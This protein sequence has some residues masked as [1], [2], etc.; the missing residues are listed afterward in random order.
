MQYNQDLSNYYKDIKEYRRL[1]DKLGQVEAHITKTIQQ[2][3]LYHIKDKPTVYEQIKTLQELY[4]PT[5]A[6]QEYRVQKAYEA[7]KVLHARRS[8]IED[9]CSEFI[10]AYN[11][12]KQLDLPE[13][14]GFRAHK[15]L[16][17]A[18]KQVDAAYAASVSLDIFKAEETWNLNRNVPIPN[19]SQLSTIL[20]NFLRYHRTT[21]SRKTNIH[22]GVFGATLNGQESPYKKKRSRGDETP[23]KPCL[24]GDNHFWGQC[25]YIDTA[26][27]TRGFVE[28]PEK[29]KKITTFEKSDTKGLLNKIREKNRRYKKH[30]SKEADKRVEPDSIDIDAGDQPTDR[31]IHDAYAVFSSAFNNQQTF[32]HYPLLH[33]WTLD[34]ATDV[35]ICNNPAEFQWKAPAAD[36]DIVLAG[37]SEMLIEAWGEVTI[38]LSTPIGI[39]TTTLKRVALIPSFFTSLVSL[40]R[41]TSSDVHFDSGRNVLYRAGT[42]QK[43]VAKLTQLGGHWLVVHR[44]QPTALSTQHSA[45]ATNQRRPQ[46]SALPLKPRLLTKPQLHV[47]LGHAGSDAIDQ[48]SSQVRG[49]LPPTGS[50]PATTNCE[51]C[52]QNKAHQIISRRI[53][54]EVGAS[55]PFETVA[56]DLI[57]LDVTGYN[58]HRYVFHGFDLC[59][60]LNFVYTIAKRDKA[61]LLKVLTRLDRS[62]KREFNTTVTF[63]IADDE[64]GYGLTDNSARAYCNQEG[65]RLQIR[66]PHTEEQNGSAERSGKNMIIR[67]RSMSVT[68]NLPLPLAP[69][70]YVAAAYLLNR[71]PTRTIGWKTPFEMAYSKQPSIAHLRVYGCRAYALR[72]QIPRGDKLSPRALI[73]YLVGYDSSNIY[74]VWLPNARSRAHQGKVIRIRDVTFKEDLFYQH[75]DE[76]DPILQGE[77]L[78]TTTYTLQMPPI[79][80]LEDS[81]EEEYSTAPE[82]DQMV[83]SSPLDNHS[84]PHDPFN[85]DPLL[86]TPV[87]TPSPNSDADSLNQASSAT[88]SRSPTPDL[89]TST[90]TSRKRKRDNAVDTND[91]NAA[92]NRELIDSNLRETHILPEGSTRAR[93]PSRKSSSFFVNKY[94]SAF[95]AASTTA[96]KT[97]FHHTDLPPE[98]RFYQDVM[99][100]PAQHKQGFI[101]A[102]HREISDVKR[103]GTYRIINWKDFNAQDHEVLPLLWVFKYKLDSEGYLTKYKARICV[104]G[105]LQTTAEDTYAATLAIRI[106]RALMAIAAYFNMEVRQYDAVNAFTNAQLAVPVYCHPPEGFSD[107][108][109]LWKLHRALYGL[110]TSPLLWYKELTKTLKELGLQEVKDAPCLWKNDKLIVFF[111]VDD[112]V[113]LARPAHTAALNDFERK[114]LR[115]YEIRSL[116]ELATFCGIQTHRCRSTGT[117]WLSQAAYLDKLSAKYPSP[118]SFN[119]PPATPLPLDELLPSEEPKS[120]SNK[121]RYAQLVGSIGYVATATR[122]DVSKAH[123]KLAEFLVNPGQLHINAAYQTLAYLYATKDQALYYDASISTDIAHIVDHDEPDFFGATDASYADHKATRKSS[124]GY[125]FFLFGGPIDW[126]ATLQR[127]VTKST[128]EAELVAASSAGTELLWWWR[129]FKDIEFDPGNEQILFCDNQQTIRL[130]TTATPRLKTSLRHVDIHHHWLRQEAQAHNINLSYI[131][132]KS[133]PA[134]GLTKLLPRQRHENWVSLLHFNTFPK[135]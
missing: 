128:T 130:V 127:C 8:N 98:P 49:I 122:P 120:D 117:M 103:K 93:K 70:I 61:T 28:D 10:T 75:Q 74:R 48:L 45:F 95:V 109:H 34:P 44:P 116:G 101:A 67:S 80:D 62:I 4:S 42:P 83:F 71:T 30:K 29:A 39:K 2:D 41:L 82:L 38:P 31:S 72:P 56:I 94:W 32:R 102:M 57:Q 33:S 126:K 52:L 135:L 123:S 76:S 50:A 110:K 69:E 17:R 133:Q 68:S 1:K 18:V 24:C 86:P 36:D 46:Y 115:R 35:H 112:I 79:Q 106:F 20:A 132:T 125:I 134:D 111:Y 3:L 7:A 54:H 21:H 9:W 131:Q 12:A 5:T 108:D 104:R 63:I 58:G 84:K 77:E 113:I 118:K 51:E 114:L 6:D 105:D 124:Q 55:R 60:K 15:D 22:G 96:S 129:L 119:R 23:S 40:S 25:P 47:L 59:T 16:V 66:A 97:R 37:G 90:Q 121:L 26:L 14:H 99:K 27:R 53:G 88:L 73:G 85:S 43:D 78:E 81:S 64:K 89:Q 65:I 91:S 87:T 107:P 100:L 11:R 13:V 92:R 19:Q